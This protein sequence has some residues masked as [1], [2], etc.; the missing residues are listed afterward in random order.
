MW[1]NSGP[2]RK[3]LMNQLSELT[4]QLSEVSSKLNDKTMQVTVQTL[5]VDKASLEK[6]VFQLDS[7]DIQELSGSLNLGNNFTQVPKSVNQVEHRVRL[8]YGGG[9]SQS[10]VQK[11]R[12]ISSESADSPIQTTASFKDDKF[13]TTESGFS[14]RF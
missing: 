3:Q 10:R 9:P 4:R 11:T 7:L 5:H 6:L 2:T 12:V 14:M 8:G 13:R 1:W